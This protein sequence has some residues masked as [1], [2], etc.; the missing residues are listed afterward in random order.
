MK[1]CPA[2]RLPGSKTTTDRVAVTVSE[3]T[4]ADVKLVLGPDTRLK[5]RVLT[6]S[7]SPVAGA[8]VYVIPFE[9]PPLL[10]LPRTTGAAGDFEIALPSTTKSASCQTLAGVSCWSLRM[11]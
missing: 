10:W 9:R 6:E 11:R 5:G 1:T 8:I 2:T 7:G 4:A 3:E